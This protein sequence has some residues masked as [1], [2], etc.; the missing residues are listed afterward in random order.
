M[1]AGVPCAL[2][3]I[4]GSRDEVKAIVTR[5]AGNGLVATPDEFAQIV[6]YLSAKKEGSATSAPTPPAPVPPSK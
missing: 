3:D 6:S 4:S 2:P 1:R 5:M